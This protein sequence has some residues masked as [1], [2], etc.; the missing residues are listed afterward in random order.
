MDRVAFFDGV[1]A[2]LFGGK[3][4]E[5]QVAG[6]GGILEAFEA[7]GDGRGKTLAY[8]LATA[9]HETGRMMVPMREGCWRNPP[10]TDAEARAAVTALARRRGPASAPARYGKPVAPHGHVYYGRGLVQLTWAD[11]YKRSSGDA[12]ADLFAEPDLM[13]D[14]TISARVLIRG[15]LDGRWNAAGKGIA[16]Y[17]PTDGADDAQNARRTVNVTDRWQEIGGHY[18]MCRAAVEAA[19][20]VAAPAPAA[21]DPAAERLLALAQWRA[22]A[23][24]AEI[25]AVTAF[26]G[27]MPA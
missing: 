15:L 12:A 2:S 6:M 23:P 11:N 16:H 17:L 21:P 7:V 13:L 10:G 20:G 1:R 4:T 27:R 18:R 3:L 25:A 19:G 22:A 26:L 8:A 5:G 14:P 24:E 9:Y